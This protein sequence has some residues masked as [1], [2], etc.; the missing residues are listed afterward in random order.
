MS[1]VV[2]LCILIFVIYWSVVVGFIF[3]FNIGFDDGWLGH[4]KFESD[5]KGTEN[6]YKSNRR[7]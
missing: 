2:Q 1:F 4:K 6:S 3:G 5:F 7:I